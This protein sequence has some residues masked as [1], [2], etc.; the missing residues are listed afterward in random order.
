MQLHQPSE[1]DVWFD[2]FLVSSIIR[3]A[4]TPPPLSP[5]PHVKGP[6]TSRGDLLKGT[7]KHPLLAIV[8]RHSRTRTSQETTRERE[9]E[10]EKERGG[11]RVKGGW[12]GGG[13]WLHG[14]CRYRDE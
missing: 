6:L 2:R 8:S 13:G 7:A 12:G 5:S 11:G 14:C 4:I 1:G 10:R 3:L 9:R